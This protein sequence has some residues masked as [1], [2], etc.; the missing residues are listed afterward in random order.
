MAIG[1]ARALVNAVV[2]RLGDHRGQLGAVEVALRGLARRLRGQS[3]ETRR[4]VEPLEDWLGQH[5]SE[6]FNSERVRVELLPEAD[7]PVLVDLHTAEV[8]WREGE[9]ERS[10]PLEA[11]SSGEQAFAYTRARLAILD[12]QDRPPQHRLI[13]LDEFG[14]FIAH[15]RLTGLLAHLRERAEEHP[16]DQVLVVLPLSRDYATMAATA[17]GEE[18]ARYGSLAA[19]IADHNYALQEIVP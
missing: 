2:D 16:N 6:W 11:F 9:S 13:V 4:Y 14:A 8:R 18:A 17:I 10:R 12:E 5:F 1:A 15:D 7:G 3:L 19:E